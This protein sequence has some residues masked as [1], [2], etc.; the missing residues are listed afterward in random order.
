MVRALV[1][2]HG[3]CSLADRERCDTAVHLAT[4]YP[5]RG[6]LDLIIDLRQALG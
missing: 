1:G 2:G 3:L 4:V 5:S 6:R